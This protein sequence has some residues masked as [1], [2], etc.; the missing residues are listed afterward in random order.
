MK[1]SRLWEPCP[2]C[3]LTAPGSFMLAKPR[4][5]AFSATN[6]SLLRLAYPPVTRSWG[7]EEQ[8]TP[9]V[10]FQGISRLRLSLEVTWNSLLTLTRNQDSSQILKWN[11]SCFK[12]RH[13]TFHWLSTQP[14]AEASPR[15]WLQCEGRMSSVTSIAL[16][17]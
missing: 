5:T 8:P 1:D 9:N 11:L 4:E 17:S 7:S 10:E 3:S 2:C 16:Q 13:R 12:R 15:Q 6:T 14:F